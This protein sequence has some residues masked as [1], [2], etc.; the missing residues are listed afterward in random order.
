[1]FLFILTGCGPAPQPDKIAKPEVAPQ[2][3][4]SSQADFSGI[5]SREGSPQS[6]AAESQ[7]IPVQPSQTPGAIFHSQAANEAL[8]RYS[9]A[10]AAIREIPAPALINSSDPLANHAAITGYI[11]ELSRRLETLKSQQTAVQQNLDPDERARFKQLQ[12]SLDSAQ[13]EE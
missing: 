7:A 8:E 3:S 4:S 2:P 13:P 12:K 5:N 1:M 9:A 11:N 10:R 6:A